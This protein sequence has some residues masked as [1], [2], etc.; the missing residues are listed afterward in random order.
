MAPG[1]R[2]AKLQQQLQQQLFPQ[3]PPCPHEM[4]AAEVIGILDEMN[5]NNVIGC[6]ETRMRIW[7][8][9]FRRLLCMDGKRALLHK[10]KLRFNV[11]EKAYET[12]S[13]NQHACAQESANELMEFIEDVEVH[14][15]YHEK[16][17]GQQ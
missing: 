15:N 11:K 7:D 2:I 17:F 5:N 6:H 12:L 14:G 1:N 4:V 10:D 16:H 9:V 13:A 8:R 3:P